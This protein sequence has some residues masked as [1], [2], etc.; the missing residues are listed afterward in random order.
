MNTKIKQQESFDFDQNFN[1]RRSKGV[2]SVKFFYKCLIADNGV[3]FLE[4]RPG[5]RSRAAGPHVVSTGPN[6]LHA[7]LTLNF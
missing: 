1:N 4:F 7:G 6:N 3:C 5:Y 2:S